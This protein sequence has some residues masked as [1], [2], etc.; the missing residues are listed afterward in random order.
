MSSCAL[1][2]SAPI[3][4]H[5]RKMKESKKSP[6]IQPYSHDF[7]C[8]LHGPKE[9]HYHLDNHV[10]DMQPIREVFRKYNMQDAAGVNLLHR[11][12][13][14]GADEILV[15]TMTSVGSKTTS[16]TTPT[17]VNPGS[18]T[19]M[20]HM[21]R[22]HE[23]KWYPLEF[24]AINDHVKM[25]D[26]ITFHERVTSNHDFLTDLGNV[27]QEMGLQDLFG[28][29]TNHRDICIREHPSD[30]VLET[31]EV[32]ERISTII[33]VPLD[34]K[35]P[36]VYLDTFYG[37]GCDDPENCSPE[38]HHSCGWTACAYGCCSQYTSCTGYG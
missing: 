25:K 24:L 9:Q 13:S 34:Q 30:T 16:K 3:D 2:R 14:A 32:D 4:T 29:Q 33:N 38:R 7:F 12:Y 23:G 28:L 36:E 37:F 11:H 31:T 19:V 21:W 1:Q 17:K 20:A 22:L 8:G 18:D 10:Y 15:E 26:V 6:L 35:Q 5:L 27:L